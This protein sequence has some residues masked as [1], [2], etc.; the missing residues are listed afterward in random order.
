MKKE[1]L[2][3]YEPTQGKHNSRDRESTLCIEI[4]IQ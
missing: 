4:Q 2:L 1:I 3:N